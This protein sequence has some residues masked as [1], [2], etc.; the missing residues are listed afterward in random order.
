MHDLGVLRKRGTSL[1]WRSDA[2]GY[3]TRFEY[4]CLYS[5]AV[6]EH[7]E[8]HSIWLTLEEAATEYYGRDYVAAIQTHSRALTGLA[9]LLGVPV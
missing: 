5:R 8:D 6:G 9:Q 3:T 1:Y 7:H 2:A 4:A